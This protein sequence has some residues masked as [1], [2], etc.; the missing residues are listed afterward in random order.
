MRTTW[1]ERDCRIMAGLPIG[2]FGRDRMD[3]LREF[4]RSVELSGLWLGY[5]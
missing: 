5:Y 3:R 4:E 2:A 1:A